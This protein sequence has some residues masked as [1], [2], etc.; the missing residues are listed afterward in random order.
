MKKL[1][2]LLSVAL[3][4]ACGSTPKESM[5]LNVNDNVPNWVFNPTIKYPL[6]ASSCVA[7]SGSFSI[8][9]AES[10]AQ[11]RAGL[12]QQLKLKVSVLDKFYQRKVQTGKGR[13][14]GATFEQVS[15]QVTEQNLVNSE[16]KKVEFAVIDNVKQL[17]SLV[18]LTEKQGDKVVDGLIEKSG[19]EID[20]TS[21]AALYE[22][23]RAKK[24]TEELEK[25][26]K[27]LGKS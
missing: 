4:S 21:K 20:P 14:I 26:L 11:A 27:K 1:S 17:C 22:E 3:L 5:N 6:A 10:V 7:W 23:F 9:K 12:A 2:L 18:A 15:K 25:E 13:N 19:V 8:D 24:A 16:V